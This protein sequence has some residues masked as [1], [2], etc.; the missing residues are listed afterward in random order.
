M[1]SLIFY[2]L[3]KQFKIIHN[4]RFVSYIFLLKQ[5]KNLYFYDEKCE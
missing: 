3:Q 5:E 2:H 1:I 4:L